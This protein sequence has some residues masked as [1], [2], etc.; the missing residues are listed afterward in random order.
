MTSK[1]LLTFDALISK[2]L[3]IIYLIQFQKTF[4][5][6]GK[7]NIVLPFIG[8]S[9]GVILGVLT[10][11]SSYSIGSTGGGGSYYNIGSTVAGGSSTSLTQ[12]GGGTPYGISGG[13][14]VYSN[15]RVLTGTG[16]GESCR[17]IETFIINLQR[18]KQPSFLCHFHSLTYWFFSL[19]VLQF[20]TFFQILLSICCIS[21]VHY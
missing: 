3:S 15:G 12:G 1:G 21:V 4:I 6:N 11:G 10:G 16:S 2:G 18:S 14:A 19:H 8:S 13:S 17:W 20:M 9:G 7:Y 5:C